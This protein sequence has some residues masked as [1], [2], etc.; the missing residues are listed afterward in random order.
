VTESRLNPSQAKSLFDLEL[1]SELHSNDW[2]LALSSNIR[3]GWR[4][5]SLANTLA[6]YGTDFTTDVKCFIMK[7]LIFC[8]FAKIKTLMSVFILEDFVA[9]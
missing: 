4:L 8:N 2:L 7:T 1:L 9:T 6:Y 5:L 3:L